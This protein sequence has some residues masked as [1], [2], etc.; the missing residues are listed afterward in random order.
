M[1]L[2]DD[3]S[4][5]DL[6]FDAIKLILH[7]YCHSDSARLRAV[8]LHPHANFKKLKTELGLAKEFHRI[9]TEGFSVA[10]LE[11]NE[12]QSQIDLL[13]MKGAMLGL[14]AILD[15]KLA[16]GLT[17]DYLSFLKENAKEFPLLTELMDR[18]YFTKEIIDSIEAIVNDKGVVR[19]SASSELE[20]I[21]QRLA[22]TRRQISRNFNRIL[23]EYKSKGWLAETNEAF[24][25][26]RRVLSVISSYKRQVRGRVLGTSKTGNWTYIEP[27]VNS[28]LAFEYEQLQDD[29]G[30][31]IRRILTELTA[32]LRG[33]IDLIKGYQYCLVELDF[34]NAKTRLALELEADLPGLSDETKIELIEAYHPLLLLT[35]KKLGIKTLPQRIEMDKFSRMLVI[36]GPNAGGKSITLKTVGLLQ[37][38][39]Q[40]ALLVPVDPVSKMCVFQ[41]ILTDIGDN[42]SIENQLSTY[43]YRLQRMKHFLQVSNRKTLL[44]LDEF[45]TGSDPDLGGALA[46]VFFEKLYSTKAF[47]RNHH[48]L[49]EYQNKGR[50]A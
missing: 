3:Q 30:V 12:L 36:S 38:M 19:D 43:S 2:V 26:D 34:I 17:N 20:E 8:D 45:G 15:I 27:E 9:K 28:E 6:E 42:Q 21:R 13:K 46:E 14:E 5:Q 39:F 37:L 47:W 10:R 4:I 25:D 32:K 44:L 23:K 29:E 18:V 50:T 33:Q 11:F 41:N 49:F 31:E 40:S 7:D 16:S 24:L 35:N 48:S 1:Q 22:N